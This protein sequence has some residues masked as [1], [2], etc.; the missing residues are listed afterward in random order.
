MADL[1]LSGDQT[2]ALLRAAANGDYHLLLGAGASRD[3]VARNGS[4][5]P[6]SQDLLKQL[7]AE[8]GVKYD[9]DDLLWRVYDRVVQ[10][11]GAKPVY[12]WLRE[13]FHEVT[14]PDWMDPFA[15]FP[16]QC[17][18]TLNVDDSFERAYGRVMGEGSRAI[19]RVNWDDQFS[20]TRDL[21]VVHLHGKVDEE[22]AQRLVFSLSE[23]AD[24]A[25]AGAAWPANFRDNYGIAPFVIVGA[26]IR[27]E[28]DIEAV[29]A[30]RKP[31][32]PAPTFYVNRSI[33]EAAAEDFRSWNVI[34]LKMTGEEFIAAWAELTGMDLTTPPAAREEI[35]LRVGRQFVELRTDRVG[36]VPRA[37]DF[38]GG[39][40]PLWADIVMRRF[41]E[42]DWI[43]EAS[44]TVKRLG[45]AG[46]PSSSAVVYTG[47]RLSGRSTGLLAIGRKLRELSWRTFLFTA[48]QRLDVE[49]LLTYAADQRPV[50]L[51]FD[52]ITDFADDVNDLI[53]RARYADLKIACIGVDHAGRSAGLLGR[54]ETNFLVNRTVRTINQ[55]LTST[56]ASRLV[57][58]LNRLTR[59]GILEDQKDWARLRHFRNNEIFDAMA[60][61]EN[62]PGFGRR[63]EDEI[64]DLS[65][66]EMRYLLF[67]SYAARVGARLH[68][69]DAARLLNT[70]SEVIIRQVSGGNRLASVLSTDGDWLRTRQRWL[71]LPYCVQRL[72]EDQSLEML[73]QGITRIAKGLGR[74]SQLERNARGLLVGSFMKYNN[75]RSVFSSADLEPWYDKLSGSFGS[76]SARFWE[77]RA[78]MSRHDGE[79]R[80]ELLSRAESY[81]RRAVTLVRDSYSLTTLGVVLLAKAARSDETVLAAY[82]DDAMDQFEAA[83]E[84]ETGN[85]VTWMA[86]LRHSLPVLERLMVIETT[87]D[88]QERIVDD[89]LRIYGQ[90]FA[91]AAS[92]DATQGELRVLRRKFDATETGTG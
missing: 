50:A 15:R 92:S 1:G 17:V 65:D 39:D 90:V 16:W 47:E 51:L 40:E 67:A 72:G 8:F 33:S 23:Y 86:Y 68:V 26:R 3:S 73:A 35:G 61:L 82:Y 2:E 55:R 6:G 28:P 4:K 52:G 69:I 71:A 91:V 45:S 70:Q 88:L 18:W 36:K 79:L 14:P 77:Q 46:V 12:D 59:L 29:V 49:A 48:D 74:Q 76:W 66:D 27:D 25:V 5:L 89:W 78:I 20:M 64:R 54:I 81:A 22:E 57:D 31:V 32:H 42:L 53:E 60:Q 41:A 10:K 11:A 34:P 75:L 43:R 87:G 30:R 38:I 80:P 62:A 37:H 56:D 63:V 19:R 9:A 21:S 85:L 44:D 24:A 84:L 13:L 83:H 7:A 58:T